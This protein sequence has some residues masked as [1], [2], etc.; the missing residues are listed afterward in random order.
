MLRRYSGEK[1]E[2]VV[3]RDKGF[4]YPEGGSGIKYSVD[5]CVACMEENNVKALTDI[6]R[7]DDQIDFYNKLK[8]A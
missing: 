5:M 6:K 8:A 3:E 1:D 2:V 7:K 4:Y